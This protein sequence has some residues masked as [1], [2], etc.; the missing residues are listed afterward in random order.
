[1]TDVRPLSVGPLNAESM[2]GLPWRWIRDHAEELGVEVIRVDGKFLILAA[3][4]LA[5]LE[6]RARPAILEP[7]RSDADELAELRARLGKQRRAG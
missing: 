6:K 7:E 3:T 2:T 1:M 5:A 4:L